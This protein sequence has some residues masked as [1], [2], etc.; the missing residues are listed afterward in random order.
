MVLASYL[1]LTV[2]GTVLLFSRAWAAFDFPSCVRNCISSSGCDPDSAG[3]VCKEAR[4]LLLDSVVSCLFF[5]CKDDLVN[6][7]DAF[8]DPVEEGCEDY[9][10]DIPE[11]KLE[12]AESLASSYI[13]KLP[14]PT[15]MKTTTVEPPRTTTK[16][17]ATEPPAASSTS[18][19][20][21]TT[22]T[23]SSAE[24]D[25]PSSTSTTH[26]GAETST[27]NTP[28]TTD[29]VPTPTSTVET[30]AAETQ[31]MSPSESSQPGD[32]GPN[33]ADSNPF[34]TKGSGALVVRPLVT[35]L[36]LPLFISILALA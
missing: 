3:C 30:P 31:T 8:L 26:R 14:S 12:A 25:V 19:T 24:E 18:S 32:S 27:S 21:T 13:S 35:L 9:R 1:R 22:T 15:T 10:R 29:E 6:F 20:S 23:S 34:A 28:T 4:E 17:S 11:S 5:N 33:Y 7:E 16:P 36:G 2:L